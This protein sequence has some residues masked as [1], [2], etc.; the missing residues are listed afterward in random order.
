MSTLV[1]TVR[2]CINKCRV[3]HENRRKTEIREGWGQ[4]VSLIV[5][6]DAHNLCS[7]QMLTIVLGSICIMNCA[8]GSCVYIAFGDDVQTVITKALPHHA[9]NIGTVAVQI[10]YSVALLVSDCDDYAPVC[11]RMLRQYLDT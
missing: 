2:L 7:K 3:K 1:A 11:L 6:I 5:N 4:F 8:F 10:S 9:L